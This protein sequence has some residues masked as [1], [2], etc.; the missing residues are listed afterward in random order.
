MSNGALCKCV[1]LLGICECLNVCLMAMPSY[2]DFQK[3]TDLKPSFYR[4]IYLKATIF[5][6][7]VGKIHSSNRK[8]TCIIYKYIKS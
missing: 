2:L 7:T 1:L 8:H 5:S 3:R 6:L 4:T